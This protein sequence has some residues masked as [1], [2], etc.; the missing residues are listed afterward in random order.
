M[1]MR[2]SPVFQPTPSSRR[3]TRIT[4]PG[5]T[6][7]GNFNPLPPRG[8]RLICSFFSLVSRHFNPLPPRGGRPGGCWAGTAARSNFNPLPP[9]GGRPRSFGGGGG[10]RP[11]ST[12]SLLAE[13]DSTGYFGRLD[14][15]FQPTPS[16]RRETP[17][18]ASVSAFF[19]FQPTPSSRRETFPLPTWRCCLV[20]FNPL[21]PRGGRRAR[22]EAV[23]QI[24]D[25][26]PLPPRGGRRNPRRFRRIRRKHFNPLPP[27]GG[28]L[29]SY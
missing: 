27:R 4:R 20:N 1:P 29:F 8:G 22:A 7:T 18:A 6:G 5:R 17:S 24:Y 3:E 14:S 28:R 23:A 11:I 19:V 25:F 15:K 2:L 21:P 9:R 10:N 26:N 16:S 12:H 13:G